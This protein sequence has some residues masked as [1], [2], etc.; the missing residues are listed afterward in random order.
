[1]ALDSLCKGFANSQL[2]L[3]ILEAEFG[4]DALKLLGKHDI[5]EP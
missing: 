5:H 4:P 2:L 1:M 3:C